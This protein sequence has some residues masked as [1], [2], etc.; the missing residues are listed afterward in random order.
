MKCVGLGNPEG[1]C[2]NHCLIINA[3]AGLAVG[4][5]LID[6]T[7]K[8]VWLNRTAESLLNV[9]LEASSGRSI[10]QILNAPQLAAFWQ[11]VREQKENAFAEFSVQWPREME[12]K[13]NATRCLDNDG[14]EIGRALLVCD[15]TRERTVQVQLSQAVATRLLALTSGHMPPKPVANLTQQELRILRMVGQGLGNDDIAAQVKISASTVR[16]HLKSL[17]KKLNLGSRS[18]AVSFSVRHHLV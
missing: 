9:R 14:N 7:G 18:E 4:V 2:L 11:D 15:V 5:I 17:Y 8:L 10:Q 1:E 3:V 12:L 16:S 6:R 13:I